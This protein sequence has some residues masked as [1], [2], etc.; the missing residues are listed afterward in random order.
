MQ[1]GFQE[2]HVTS[3]SHKPCSFPRAGTAR[4]GNTRPG[5]SAPPA[6]TPCPPGCRETTGPPHPE[7]GMETTGLSALRAWLAPQGVKHLS[8][9]TC[10]RVEGQTTPVSESSRLLLNF[11]EASLYLKERG[12]Q[13]TSHRHA[14]PSLCQ[15]AKTSYSTLA[16]LLL[17]T[18]PK[19][20]LS[21]LKDA[22]ARIIFCN[23]EGIK[24]RLKCILCS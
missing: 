8:E 20:L 11:S 19:S 18:Y 5:H 21:R 24:E 4:R 14:V 9:P 2:L 7:A 6:T 23:L 17:L 1:T 12:C 22:N 13:A 10:P 3:S 15:D 16:E